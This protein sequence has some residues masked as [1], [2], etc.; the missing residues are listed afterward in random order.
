MIVKLGVGKVN[1]KKT[2]LNRE[3]LAY[4]YNT[5]LNMIKNGTPFKNFLFSDESKILTKWWLSEH[6][7]KSGMIDIVFEVE[8]N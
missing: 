7:V 5:F 1:T 8:Q 2:A 6:V 4:E 3:T